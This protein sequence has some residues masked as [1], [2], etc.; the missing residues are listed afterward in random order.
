M[1]T[2]SRS[3]WFLC[4][5][6]LAG[7]LL[8]LSYG[9]EQRARTPAD[10]APNSPRLMS[11]QD[12]QALPSRT[13]DRRVPYGQDSSQYG[14]LRIPAGAGPHPVVILVHGGCFKAAYAQ[15]RDVAAMGVLVGAL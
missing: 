9:C 2:V 3:Y 11:P 5:P 8:A 4:V 13:P 1:A 12:L 6:V 10:A 15:A 7:A 14:E